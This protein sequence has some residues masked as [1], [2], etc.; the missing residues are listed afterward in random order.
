MPFRSTLLFALTPFTFFA[1]APMHAA[2]VPVLRSPDGRIE[3]SFA[4]QPGKNASRASGQ[5]TY[6]VRFRGKPVLDAS[7]L[8]L[9]LEGA[10]V[11]GSEVAPPT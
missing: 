9:D 4:V 10:E 5:L 1:A 2:D 6:A 3:M 7:K 8:G 11:L